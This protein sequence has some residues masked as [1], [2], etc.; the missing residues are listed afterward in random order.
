MICARRCS[1][2]R[3]QASNRTTTSIPQPALLPITKS[4]MTFS[5]RRAA[6]SLSLQSNLTK[7]PPP[8][9][10]KND[11]DGIMAAPKSHAHDSMDIGDDASL[12][13]GCGRVICKG[14]CN[15]E[16]LNGYF[17]SFQRSKSNISLNC[18]GKS[19]RAV[20]IAVPLCCEGYLRAR[21]RTCPSPQVILKQQQRLSPT[22]GPIFNLA[23]HV[24]VSTTHCS[25][26]HPS[27]FVSF[28]HTFPSTIST[29]Q[30]EPAI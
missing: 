4:L 13:P 10:R 20:S 19:S 27:I 8:R 21:L 25:Y 11:E 22:F 14:C 15:E 18:S 5:P 23:H 9:K 28:Y 2:K 26:T 6:L 16:V 7:A 30:F 29:I 1:S 24:F 3:V 17:T 12:E